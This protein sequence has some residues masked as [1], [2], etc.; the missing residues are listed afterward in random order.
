MTIIWHGTKIKISRLLHHTSSNA[1][2][3]NE[4]AHRLPPDIMEMI[5]I[6]LT[7]NLY[8]LKSCSLTCRSWY[9]AAVPYIY[10]TLLLGGKPRPLRSDFWP[11]S[12]LHGRGLTP[13]VK[14]IWVRQ[15]Y[16]R[17]LWFLPRAFNRR[18]LRYFSA[19]TNVQTLRIQRLDI[20]SFIPGV[21]RYFGQFSPTL[22]SIALSRPICNTPQQ[23]SYFLSLFS[24]LDNICI[25]L[26]V[27]LNTS[28]PSPELAPFS[29]PTLRGTLLL[30][31]FRP[32]ETWT[33]MI[34][35]CG[36]LRFRHVELHKVGSCAPIILEACAETL[37]T[38]RLY[39]ADAISQ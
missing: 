14:E 34:A 39:L 1:R 33:Y 24:N 11:L 15:W 5:L 35:V 37:E 6:H 28:T 17:P 3:T 13:L 4:S 20:H 8:A 21:E 26:L 25:S 10:H 29:A 36:G 38:L 23:L 9:I 31:S 7:D 16:T 22:R 19:F 27:L 32:V 18:N 30:S 2:T 12:K